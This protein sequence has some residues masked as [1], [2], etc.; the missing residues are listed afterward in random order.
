MSRSPEIVIVG[1]GV[2]GA[3]TARHLQRLGRKVLLLDAWAP[4]HARASSGGESRLTRGSYGGDEIYTLMAW[5][6]LAEW[7]ALSARA[8]LPILHRCG[9]LIFFERAEPNDAETIQVHRRL[10]LPTQVLD[11]P[12][13]SRRFPMVDFTG[14]EIGIYEPEFGALMAR[15]AVQTL[16]AEFVADGGAYR[17]AAVRPPRP[18]DGPLPAV[19]LAGGERIEA[20]QFVFAC[21]PW[22]PKLFPDLLGR[23]IFPT[24]QEVFFFAPQPGDTRFEPDALPGWADFNAGD[25]FYGFPD[26]EGRGFKIAHDRHGPPID[27]DAG[28]RKP[29]DAALAKVRAYME[30]RFPALAGR[31][32]NEAR[33]CQY[34]NSDSG[35]FLIDRHPTRPNIVLVG[36]GSGHGF[37]HGPAVG[38]YA[39]QLVSASLGAAEPRFS[40]ASKG[41]RQNR[42]VH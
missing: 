32:L 5:E 12:A 3:W 22:L 26:L 37:K 17:Q 10:G 34:E 16:V 36:A 35:D 9:N 31:P 15:R 42:A 19:D 33:V 6:S 40:L 13:M 30:R 39:A 38:R 1:A 23:R 25:M 21:G 20:E 27:P 29:S 7:S 18:E 24:R 11:R 28:D 14:I 41:E 4:A 8:G 2:F